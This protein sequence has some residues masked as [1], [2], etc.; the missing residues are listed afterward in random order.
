MIE[1][2]VQLDKSQRIITCFYMKDRVLQI[3][4]GCYEKY[5]KKVIHQNITNPNKDNV[6]KTIDFII[7][8]TLIQ[9]IELFSK[10]FL[11][12]VLIKNR[13]KTVKT[14]LNYIL[15]NTYIEYDN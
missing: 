11:K 6:I 1:S 15:K 12:K 8:Q 9:V 4:I 7:G 2:R 5:W 3:L 14:G 10:I 13:K